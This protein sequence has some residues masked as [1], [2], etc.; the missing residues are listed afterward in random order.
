MITFLGHF[1]SKSPLEIL[2]WTIEEIA[3]WYSKA[4]KLHNYL[5]GSAE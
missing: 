2:E 3:E 1:F 5:Y 4:I